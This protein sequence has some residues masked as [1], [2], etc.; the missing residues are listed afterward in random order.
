MIAD[1]YMP[2][3]QMDKQQRAGGA[4]MLGGFLGGILD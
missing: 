4:G 3:A 2:A 1:Q